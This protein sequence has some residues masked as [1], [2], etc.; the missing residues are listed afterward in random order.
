MLVVERCERV[1]Q[2]DQRVGRRAAVLAA[3]LRAGERRQLDRRLRGAPQGDR[4]RRQ[5]GRTLPM[6]EISIA[7]DWNS[8]GFEI[9]Y[10]FRALPT[11]SWPSITSLIPTG[12]RPSQARSAPMCAST[13][14]FESELPRP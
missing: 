2:D 1:Q 6:S 9:G 8:S 11:S 12:G 3:V 7:S 10:V 13:F 14:D 4:E 5:P